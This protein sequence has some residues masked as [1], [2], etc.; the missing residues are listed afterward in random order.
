MEHN[1]KNYLISKSKMKHLK[2]RKK[3][4]Q[5]QQDSS[6]WTLKTDKT[7]KCHQENR[8]VTFIWTVSSKK[9]LWTHAKCS[10]TDHAVHWHS[11]AG[12]WRKYNVAST[13][14][15]RHDIASTLYLRHVPAG[16]L[17]SMFIVCHITKTCLYNDDPL[18]P[19]FYIVKLGF[20]GVYIIFYI[21]AHK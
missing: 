2:E 8:S 14:M 18:K 20:T 6:T 21:S 12:T 15:Q 3:N 16:S 5:I 13:S 4:K 17:A 11:P 1:F 19:H 10:D 9:S 7:E